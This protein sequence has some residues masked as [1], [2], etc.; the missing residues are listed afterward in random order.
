MVKLEINVEACKSCSFCINVC[1]KK[2]LAIGEQVN[3]S[4]YRYVVPKTMESCV[5][6]KLCAIMCPECAIELYNG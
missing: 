3:K 1:A 2:V 5:G 4:G 6:C